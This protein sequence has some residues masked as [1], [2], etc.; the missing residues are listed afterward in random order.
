MLKS[1]KKYVSNNVKFIQQQINGFHFNEK[2]KHNRTY[3]C[4]ALLSRRIHLIKLPVITVPV[5]NGGGKLLAVIRRF[6]LSKVTHNLRVLFFNPH[7]TLIV[8]IFIYL[9]DIFMSF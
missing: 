9:E 3:S 8:N 7:S 2:S 4:I 1:Y 5:A 6:M